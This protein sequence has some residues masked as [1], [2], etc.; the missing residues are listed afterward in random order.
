M[1]FTFLR[2]RTHVY[3]CVT[4]STKSQQRR[5]SRPPLQTSAHLRE[6]AAGSLR[7]GI[8]RLP[9]RK[10]SR[11]T[12]KR[13]FLISKSAPSARMI[14]YICVIF[15]SPAWA[16][17]RLCLSPPLLPHRAC[18]HGRT[19]HARF[20]LQKTNRQKKSADF[21]YFHIKRK[22]VHAIYFFDL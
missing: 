18:E 1:V 6:C 4:K 7:A 15:L 19:R 11:R 13:L 21:L 16:E 2:E 17:F 12:K 8:V 3:F 22:V 14:R 20:I 9:A 5:A 10:Q